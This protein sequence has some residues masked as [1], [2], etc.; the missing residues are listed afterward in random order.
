MSAPAFGVAPTT[1]NIRCAVSFPA[2]PFVE[3]V[4]FQ[5]E[6]DSQI[7]SVLICLLF[8]IRVTVAAPS[9]VTAA[10]IRFTPRLESAALYQPPSMDK[11]FAKRVTPF[12]LDPPLIVT[13]LTQIVV[14]PA[15]DSVL[16]GMMFK[17]SL[18][19]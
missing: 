6:M 18:Y 16:I 19:N 7:C 5:P 13:G 8:K 1:T 15:V 2:N 17:R 4:I 11:L 12:S 3:Y 9:F 14:W 10:V